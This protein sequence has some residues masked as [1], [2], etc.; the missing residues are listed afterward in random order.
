MPR[1]KCARRLHRHGTRLVVSAEAPPAKLYAGRSGAEA[2]EFE[3]T[4]SRLIEMQGRDWLD[5]WTARHE[6]GPA[7]AA[8]S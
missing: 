2:F 4:A 8:A 1:M 5:A 7:T 3:R 6:Q